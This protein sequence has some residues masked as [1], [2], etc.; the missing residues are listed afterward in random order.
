MTA[1][2]KAASVA[3]TEASAEPASRQRR[4]DQEKPNSDGRKVNRADTYSVVD[5]PW[6]AEKTKLERR[7]RAVG[8]CSIRETKALFNVCGT[9]HEFIIQL[10]ISR[11][12]GHEPDRCDQAKQREYKAP[13]INVVDF[14]RNG[15]GGRDRQQT[16]Q[17][18]PDVGQRPKVAADLAVFRGKCVSTI[19]VHGLLRETSSS[20]RTEVS[21]RAQWQFSTRAGH[22]M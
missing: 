4:Q 8:K 3:N 6:D 13:A 19:L 12:V 1:S 10:V 9:S 7:A 17:L 18:E 21:W 15:Y 5:F 16:Q 20:C 11:I 14:E 2:P 22:Q